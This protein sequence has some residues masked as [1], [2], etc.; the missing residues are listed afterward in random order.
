MEL[1][2]DQGENFDDHKRSFSFGGEFWVGNRAF[3]VLGLQPHLVFFF[4]GF[5]TL[6]VSRGH[7]LAGKFMSGK[8]FIFD[9]IEEF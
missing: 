1:V 2:D 8:S 4:K 9:G 6:T 3:Q 7:D 5:E